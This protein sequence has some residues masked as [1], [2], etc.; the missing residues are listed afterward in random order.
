MGRAKKFPREVMA[1]AES[2]LRAG[3]SASIVLEGGGANFST[4]PQAVGELE[5]GRR[6]NN[7]PHEMR[8]V[9]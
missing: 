4:R 2:R 1:R 6:L 9:A 3:G 7:M 5:R 8:I